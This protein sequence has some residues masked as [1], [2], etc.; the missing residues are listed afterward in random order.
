[1]YLAGHHFGNNI[2]PAA[3]C[4]L[5]S[6]R[7]C[8]PTDG[9]A[10]ANASEVSL[11]ADLVRSGVPPGEWLSPSD[12]HPVYDGLAEL[13]DELPHPDGPT[14]RVAY[15][16]ALCC[17]GEISL[18]Y[19]NR[20]AAAEGYLQRAVG[21]D[22]SNALAMCL[23][24]VCVW[25]SGGAL[26]SAEEIKMPGGE[27]WRRE[28][29]MDKA[30]DLLFEAATLDPAHPTVAA[31]A[32]AFLVEEHGAF[33]VAQEYLD[34]ALQLEPSEPDLYHA[35]AVL[36]ARG[37]PEAA[38]QAGAA[39]GR[40]AAVDAARQAEA[41][42]VRAWKWALSLHPAHLVSVE[43]YTC[44]LQ[45]QQRY[46]EAEQVVRRALRCHPGSSALALKLALMKHL[47]LMRE[48]YTEGGGK[49]GGG[50]SHD[51]DVEAAVGVGQLYDKALA[52]DPGNCQVWRFI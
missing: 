31:Y 37:G 46:G 38:R 2:L 24:G 14:G 11:L 1:M 50:R 13:P 17:L 51:A 42:A 48:V 49:L 33:T 22:P 10:Q 3:T 44:R 5:T 15:A 18:T 36:H 21:I 32:S 9:F 52:L 34:T 20:P 45:E 27:V 6:R 8:W 19:L 30:E 25:R 23:W 12:V 4:R 39:E 35:Y 47:G 40:A 41:E 7:S 26:R 43:A 16:M 28:D 29:F